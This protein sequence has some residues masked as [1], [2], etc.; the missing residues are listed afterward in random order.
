MSCKAH[1][2]PLGKNLTVHFLSDKNSDPYCGLFDCI[3]TSDSGS[4]DVV[5]I[6]DLSRQCTENSQCSHRPMAL[7]VSLFEKIFHDEVGNIRDLCYSPVPQR[8]NPAFSIS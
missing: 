5:L 7:I 1:P 2:L 3:Q 4:L 6:H 8:E